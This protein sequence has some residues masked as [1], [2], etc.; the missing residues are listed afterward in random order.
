MLKQYEE[1]SVL[2]QGDDGAIVSIRGQDGPAVLLGPT[3]LG[4]LQQIAVKAADGSEKAM[5]LLLLEMG[6]L[7]G[8]YNETCN[9]FYGSEPG[10]KQLATVLEELKELR[11]QLSSM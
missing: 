9:K 7:L 1:I 11:R 2:E 3:Y 4:H 10:P 8:T 6:T 5:R